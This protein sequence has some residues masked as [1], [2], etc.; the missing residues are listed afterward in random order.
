MVLFGLTELPALVI[1]SAHGTGVLG[2]AALAAHRLRL[3]SAS[4]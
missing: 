2:F 4:G 1:M 3:G